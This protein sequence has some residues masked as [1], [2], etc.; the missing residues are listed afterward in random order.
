MKEEIKM[1]KFVI[2]RDA[3]DIKEVTDKL[4]L[5]GFAEHN[6]E[7]IIFRIN[8]CKNC[9]KAKKCRNCKCNPLDK[10]V[11]P[12]SCNKVYPNIMNKE[13]WDNFKLEN[14]IEII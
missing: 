13:K 12:I 11:E 6:V 2:K 7:Q 4:N 5:N 10:V 3:P 8:A 14:N 1:N 9:F